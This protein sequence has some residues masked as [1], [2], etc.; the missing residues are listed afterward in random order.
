MWDKSA[1]LLL[2]PQQVLYVDALPKHKT[3]ST[4]ST[5]LLADSCKNVIAYH[6]KHLPSGGIFVVQG[7]CVP[8]LPGR[9]SVLGDVVVL[10]LLT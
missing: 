8:S 6:L 1:V 3:P 10:Y 7:L 5:L 9:R 2:L 4:T